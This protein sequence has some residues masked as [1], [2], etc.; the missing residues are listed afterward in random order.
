MD[1]AE[2]VKLAARG[3]EK[4]RRKNLFNSTMHYSAAANEGYLLN[5][6]HLP[7]YVEAAKN[8]SDAKANDNNFQVRPA[9]AYAPHALSS[10][11]RPVEHLTYPHFSELQGAVRDVHANT[12]DA[13]HIARQGIADDINRYRLRIRGIPE[14]LHDTVLGMHHQ[15][16]PSEWGTF[17]APLVFD[18]H[19]GSVSIGGTAYQLATPSAPSGSTRAPAVGRQQRALRIPSPELTA[20]L[21][22][23]SKHKYLYAGGVSLAGLGAVGLHLH[24]QNQHEAEVLAL[25][26][27]AKTAE[28]LTMHNSQT[29]AYEAGA[30]F[31][32]KQAHGFSFASHEE[33]PTD[34]AVHPAGHYAAGIA[35]GT[36]VGATAGALSGALLLGGKHPVGKA[37]VGGL[38]GMGLGAGLGYHN[39]DTKRR[40][41]EQAY[42]AQDPFALQK[43]SAYDAGSQFA[44]QLIVERLQ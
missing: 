44:L 17:N 16:H 10:S 1:L 21:Q 25:H 35:K 19:T 33:D 13:E 38:I 32:A 8:F 3:A 27:R 7:G 12:P 14:H 30:A 41:V 42:G 11:F 26:T 39:V 6:A 4:Q 15:A 22:H 29:A 28:D 37:G 43:M 23:L 36:A 31:A 40:A 2:L 9:T 34:V 18:P 5:P 20:A 24:N